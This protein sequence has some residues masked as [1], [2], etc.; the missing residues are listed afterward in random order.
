MNVLPEVIEVLRQSVRKAGHD[1][2][3]LATLIPADQD[4][5]L[6]ISDLA[7][8]NPYAVDV[9]YADNRRACF[10]GPSVSRT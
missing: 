5:S 3:A 8:L 10:S 2:K 4:F 7:E 9:R 1:L 6:R